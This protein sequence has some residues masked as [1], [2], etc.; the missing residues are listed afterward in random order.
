MAYFYDKQ[1]QEPIEINIHQ[2][3]NGIELVFSIT[4]NNLIESIAGAIVK[5]KLKEQKTGY[6]IKR[7]CTITD[8]ELGECLYILT[9]EDTSVYGTFISEIEI[10]YS[11][12]RI[13][14]NYAP[15]ILNINKEIIGRY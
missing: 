6:E 1:D 11:N 15:F 10:V 12:G 13:L 5:L 3:D 2:Y 14:S 8:A 4:N 7:K 9:T